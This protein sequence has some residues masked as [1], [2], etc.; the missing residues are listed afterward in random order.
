MERSLLDASNSPGMTRNRMRSARIC[1][2]PVTSFPL[3]RLLA[4][5]S[6]R[7]FFKSLTTFQGNK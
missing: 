3:P 6:L 2:N 1:F 7:L 4:K 5:N